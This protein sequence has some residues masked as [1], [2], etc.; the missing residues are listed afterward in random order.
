[1]GTSSTSEYEERL[2][3][4][5]GFQKVAENTAAQTRLVERG[6]GVFVYDTEGREYLEATASFYVASLGYQNEEL[7]DA[8]ASQYRSLP[9]FVSALNRT[10]A[11]SVELADRIRKLSPVS[12][13]RVVFGSTGSEAIDFL[14]K[15]LRPKAD[16][17]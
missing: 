10:S 1:M 14:I 7:I 4:L 3:L 8:V 16:S 6:D 15:L 17:V 13:A 5:L 11:T 12:D 9:F 2:P